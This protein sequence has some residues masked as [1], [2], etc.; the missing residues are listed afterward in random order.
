MRLFKHSS[1]QTLIEVLVVA[2]I[3]A[4]ALTGIVS[5]V[6]NSTSK[7]RLAKEKTVATRLA[8]EGIEWAKRAREGE[9]WSN[10][11]DLNNG[12]YCLGPHDPANVA[13]FEDLGAFNSACIVNNRYTRKITKTQDGGSVA[14]TVEISWTGGAPVSVSTNFYNRTYK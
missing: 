2:G 6:V 9:S 11:Y 5:G 8:Q 4:V 10:F 12:E 3:L 13:G 14:V 1:G 7:N